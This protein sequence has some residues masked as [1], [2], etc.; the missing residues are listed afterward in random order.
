MRDEQRLNDLR[1]TSQT[2][3][4]ARKALAESLEKHRTTDAAKYGALRESMQKNQLLVRLVPDNFLYEAHHF[5]ASCRPQL[6]FLYR[7]FKHLG[8]LVVFSF[9]SIAHHLYVSVRGFGYFHLQMLT[10]Q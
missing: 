7:L 1:R 10:S 6:S 9:S 3:L 4:N 5:V 8:A 2:S